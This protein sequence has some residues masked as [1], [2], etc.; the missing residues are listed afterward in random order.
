MKMYENKNVLLI[1]GGGTLGTPITEELLKLGCN[2][3]VICPEEKISNNEHLVYHRDYVSEELL[4]NLFAKKHYHGIVNLIH[5][6]DVEKYKQIHPLLSS[7]TDHLIFLSS[8]RVYA[9]EEHPIT[10]E[11]PMLLDVSK[12]EAFLAKENYA[13]S[14]AKGERYLRASGTTN[15]TA[16]RP[17][18]S[19]SQYRFDLI[20]TSGQTIPKKAQQNEPIE[21]PLAAKDLTAGWDWAGNSGKL[22]A[23]LLFKPEALGQ[24][25][26]I[27]TAQNLKWSEAADLFTKLTGAK[28]E[29]I[30]TDSYIAKYV[31]D[32][33]GHLWRLIYDRFFDREMDNSKVL[34][35]T[36]LTAD[37]FLPVEEGLRIE[38]RKA[39]W[40]VKE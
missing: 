19:F 7:N 12:D 21:L 6:P 25:Y 24:S 36:G 18:I 31:G 33:K 37:D 14:K 9:D 15:W 10:E 11:S 3:D 5:Y 29:W 30:D 32:D 23:H 17:V 8:Y 27:S 22:I 34:A 35:A 39:G 1:G 26:T 4:R 38:L 20:T 2:V 28:F 16:V 40:D 13:L